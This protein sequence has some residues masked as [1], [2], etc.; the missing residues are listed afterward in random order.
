MNLGARIEEL[1]LLK[2]GWLDG[3]GVPPAHGGLA[4]LN[5]AFDEYYPEELPRPYL[6][7]TPEGHVLAE[8]SLRPRSITLQI[9]LSARS[10]DWHALDLVTDAEETRELDLREPEC[11]QWLARRIRTYGAEVA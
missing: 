7:P 1:K 5:R 9:D 3:T 6:F 8:W 11:W 4:W 10:G 2:P